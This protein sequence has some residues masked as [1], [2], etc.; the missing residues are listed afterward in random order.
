MLSRARGSV[1]EV[2]TQLEI[3]K[4]LKFL[5][6]EKFDELIATADE[7]GRLIDG[8]IKSIRR[9]LVSPLRPKS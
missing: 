7:V 2:Q 4:N 6:A 8:L 9:Q 5:T 1:Y 3:A